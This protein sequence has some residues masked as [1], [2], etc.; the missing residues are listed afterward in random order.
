MESQIVL[1]KLL[2]GP[3]ARMP[4]SRLVESI[5]KEKNRFQMR[6]R[7]GCRASRTGGWIGIRIGQ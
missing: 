5:W 6:V 3:G 2:Q 4:W 1:K 7:A